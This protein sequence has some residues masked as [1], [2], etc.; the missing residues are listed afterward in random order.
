M[1]HVL[2]VPLHKKTQDCSIFFGHALKIDK[3]YSRCTVAHVLTHA[4]QN[5]HMDIF[6]IRGFP[7]VLTTS[8]YTS[9]AAT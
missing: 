4:R 6:I 8:H 7:H 1:E 9:V 2:S 5:L 3:N